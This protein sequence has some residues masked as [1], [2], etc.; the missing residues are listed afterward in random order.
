MKGDKEADYLIRSSKWGLQPEQQLWQRAFSINSEDTTRMTRKGDIVVLKGEQAATATIA[1]PLWRKAIRPV[2]LTTDTA[3]V[4]VRF[5][6]GQV[7]LE[8]DRARDMLL[9]TVL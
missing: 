4:Q 8:L 5:L 2:E 1:C 7:R 6:A 9:R 3:G